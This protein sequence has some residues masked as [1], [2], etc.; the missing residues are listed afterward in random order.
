MGYVGLRQRWGYKPPL[1]ARLDRGH[2]LSQGLAFRYLFNEGQG[3]A[4][5]DLAGGHT[6][7]LF[8][9]TWARGER[10]MLCRSTAQTPT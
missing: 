1:G 9:A 7:T 5:F 3:L 2:T 4:A 8:N 10:A 6:A